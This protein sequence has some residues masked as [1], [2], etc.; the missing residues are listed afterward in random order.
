MRT[1]YKC[2]GFFV[3]KLAKC[4]PKFDEFDSQ[5]YQSYQKLVS[6]SKKY[7]QNVI[8]CG[9]LW[10]TCF[11][12]QID[13]FG[14]VQRKCV[15]SVD[16]QTVKMCANLVDHLEQSC[17]MNIWLQK[18]VSIKPRMYPCQVC[19]IIRLLLFLA[20]RDL[21]IVVCHYRTVVDLVY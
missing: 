12:N 2:S 1:K 6:V 7:L 15:N 5:M 19:C 14:A 16:L 8:K 21:G 3:Q 4:W 17:K 9:K 18:S 13:D 11:K 20:S 10:S